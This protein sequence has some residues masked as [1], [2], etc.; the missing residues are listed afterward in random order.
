MAYAWPCWKC[1]M[2]KIRK[3]GVPELMKQGFLRNHV[4]DGFSGAL[5]D[6]SGT[7]EILLRPFAVFPL[8][9]ALQIL[10]RVSLIQR[11]LQ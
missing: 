10:N 11:L 9:V 6:S 3:L 7:T 5:K 8:S 2:R 4:F 1:N